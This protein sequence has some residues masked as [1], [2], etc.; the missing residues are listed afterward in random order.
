MGSGALGKLS[1]ASAEEVSAVYKDLPPEAQANLKEALAALHKGNGLSIRS[2]ISGSVAAVFE[3]ASAETT[4]M[5]L[6]NAL[7]AQVPETKS[8][9]VKIFI[10]AEPM[11]QYKTLG[12]QGVDAKGEVQYTVEEFSVGTK[13]TQEE[14]FAIFKGARDGLN[15]LSKA[16]VD[17]TKSLKNPP[18]AVKTVVAAVAVLLQKPR[19]SWD[20]LRKMLTD[21]EFLPSLLSFEKDNVSTETLNELQWYLA[22]PDFQQERVK[23]VSAACVCL[24]DWVDCMH[25]FATTF[26]RLHMP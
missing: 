7:Y 21:Q 18:Q 24:R 5:D 14:A 16:A 23:R 8:Q 2:M 15:S 3:A 4:Y 12:E 1:E 20:D 13:L 26:Q 25:T 10:S 17:E 11:D 19:G 22:H 6:V 9:V